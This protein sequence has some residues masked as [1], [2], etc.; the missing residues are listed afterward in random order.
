VTDPFSNN[1]VAESFKEIS[2]DTDEWEPL[3]EPRAFTPTTALKPLMKD[4]REKLKSADLSIKA[5]DSQSKTQALPV[6]IEEIIVQKAERMQERAA[7]LRLVATENPEAIRLASELKSKALVMISKGRDVRIK[8]CK[9]QD[10]RIS[11]LSYLLDE[12]QISIHKMGNRKPIRGK[13]SKDWLQEYEIKDKTTTPP[14]T[15]WYAHFY[16]EKENSPFDSII[17][18]KQGKPAAHLKTKAQR[19]MGLKMQTTQEQRGD[20]IIDII[21]SEI[22]LA[23]AKK[24]FENIN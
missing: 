13:N 14:S 17:I 2:P 16:Y 19:L 3:V 11:S 4:A 24:F 5:A 18:N 7:G 9:M 15:L 21:R 1:Q 22:N 12:E 10:P 8:M 6:Y 23:S 20:K